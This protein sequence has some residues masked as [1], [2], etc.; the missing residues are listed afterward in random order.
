MANQ[1]LLDYI[2][3]QEQQGVGGGEIKKTL[4]E[5]GWQE[6]DI[7]EAFSF[8]SQN[9]SFKKPFILIVLLI[10][11]VA[12]A[13]VFGGAVYFAIKSKSETSLNVS[14][15]L[16]KVAI[17]CEKEYQAGMG[18][19]DFLF[20]CYSRVAHENSD[21]SICEKINKANPVVARQ[22]PHI[23]NV[24]NAQFDCFAGIEITDEHNIICSEKLSPKELNYCLTARAIR[25][26]NLKLCEGITMPIYQDFCYK[27]LAQTNKDENVCLKV[28]DKNDRFSCY[29]DVAMVKKDS[30]IC[31]KSEDLEHKNICLANMVSALKDPSICNKIGND[32]LNNQYREACF[33]NV[34]VAVNNPELCDKARYAAECVFKVALQNKNLN[35]CGFLKDAIKS[36]QCL[37]LLGG[38]KAETSVCASLPESERN[39]CISMIG[40]FGED[41]NFCEKSEEPDSCYSSFSV[42][43]HDIASCDKVKSWVYSDGCYEELALDML[44]LK[45]CDKLQD[46]N[47]NA[48]E[49]CYLAMAHLTGDETICAGLNNMTFGN[50]FKD[51]CYQDIAEFKN[52]ASYCL[53]IAMADYRDNCFSQVAYGLADPLLCSSVVNKSERDKCVANI[54]ETYF[55]GKELKVDSAPVDTAIIG[56]IFRNDKLGLEIKLPDDW[57]LVRDDTTVWDGKLTS[58]YEPLISPNEI[59]QVGGPTLLFQNGYREADK[60]EIQISADFI[61][62]G[63]SCV[64]EDAKIFQDSKNS[65]VTNEVSAGTIDGRNFI[66]FIQETADGK[67]S[68]SVTLEATPNVQFTFFAN[69]AGHD[70]QFAKSQEFWDIISS[71]K[72]TKTNFGEPAV[73]DLGNVKAAEVDLETATGTIRGF[74]IPQ[75]FKFSTTEGKPPKKLSEFFLLRGRAF[76]T[77]MMSIEVRDKNDSFNPQWDTY[78][79][80]I[81]D[82]YYTGTISLKNGTW[83]KAYLEGGD[84]IYETISGD[85]RIMVIHQPGNTPILVGSSVVDQL[86]GLIKLAVPGVAEPR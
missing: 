80:A 62:R 47:N 21:F 73:I 53:K 22:A 48:K 60:K 55:G 64:S 50:N 25:T 41:S 63:I 68:G 78:Y 24:E 83:Q 65:A 45:F 37:L 44:D 27:G 2:K 10:A 19:Y 42:F 35:A 86:A 4:L 54:S 14:T 51:S 26:R 69:N 84:T 77:E 11:G 56:N 79:R 7:Q 49:K 81:L 72:W 36:K 3:Q 38:A 34:A 28:A 12:V 39:E 23:L 70:A 18:D 43:N 82:K 1:Q 46:K 32:Y 40:L 8:G 20:S 5:N 57:I 30:S 6:S 15:K 75:C 58:Y 59:L 29:I 76:G 17:D 74:Y 16:K 67:G 33:G 9:K 66:K 52:D 13:T 85:N 31:D 61:L 71:F